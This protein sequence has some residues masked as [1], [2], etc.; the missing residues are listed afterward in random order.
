MA[1]RACASTIARCTLPVMAF[2]SSRLRPIRSSDCRRSIAAISAVVVRPD[3]SSITSWTRIFIKTP[4]V[5]SDC[6][7]LPKSLG[8]LSP[9]RLAK[10]SVGENVPRFGAKLLVSQAFIE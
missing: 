4:C 9:G 5:P 1:S 8:Y 6:G 7:Q 3:P 10:A 2:A